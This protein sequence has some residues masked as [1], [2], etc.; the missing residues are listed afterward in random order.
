MSDVARIRTVSGVRDIVSIVGN[1]W[2]RAASSASTSASRSRSSLT[3]SSCPSDI[4]REAH[5]L[6][7][8]RM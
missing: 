3:I 5:A 8:L 2:Q 4:Q 7:S 6:N 1:I